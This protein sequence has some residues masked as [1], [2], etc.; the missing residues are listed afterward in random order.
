MKKWV[1]K[2]GISA[3]CLMLAQTVC[4][5]PAHAFIKLDFTG[6]VADILDKIKQEKIKYEEW[7]KSQLEKLNQKV[8]KAFGAEGAELFKS[9]TS[10]ATSIVTSAAKGQFN[11]GDFT[12]KGFMS[13]MGAQLGNYK[14]DYANIL[15][16][17]QDY[18]NA[19]ER[20][21]L[22]KKAAMETELLK[23]S[24][25][26]AALNDL[27]AQNP[28]DPGNA[29]RLKQMDELDKA[30]ADL[31]KQIKDNDEQQ[32]ADDENTKSLENKMKSLQDQI[33]N[34]TAQ[35]SQ[36][37]LMKSLQLETSKLFGHG[38]AA[39]QEEDNKE[40]YET[41]LSKLFLAEDEAE[42]TQNV[43]R[44]MK[45]RKKEYYDALKNSLET[46]ITTYGSIEEISER[47]KACGEASTK[48]ANGVFGASAMRIC[49][50]LQNTKIA[51]R[52]MEIL[53][54]LIRY[55]TTSEMQIWTNKYKLKDYEKDVTKFNL[56]DYILKKESM[57]KKGKNKLNQAI[58]NKLNSL[59]GM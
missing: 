12:A 14:L 20:A 8:L 36:D 19:Q 38:T 26:R 37:N 30:M 13:A 15:N 51:A 56:D 27:I 57:L 24:S 5:M 4:V 44:I 11:A 47:S 35:T 21:K 25:Q 7:Y 2:I 45:I 34:I 46:V 29:D 32:V 53:L 39:A 10:N 42:N 49:T 48:M 41:A 55:E 16:Q 50:E 59:T 6:P 23:L 40:L 33:S 17:M 3:V 1:K 9:V 52:Y 28:D 54:A 18:V 31:Q 58:D 22:D 43:A